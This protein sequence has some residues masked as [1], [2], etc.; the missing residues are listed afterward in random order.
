MSRVY[1]FRIVKEIVGRAGH[2]DGLTDEEGLDAS[3]IPNTFVINIGDQFA[4]WT[5]KPPCPRIL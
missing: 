4:R 2:S 3:Y 1:R 5:S